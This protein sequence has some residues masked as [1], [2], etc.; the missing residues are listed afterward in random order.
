MSKWLLVLAISQPSPPPEGDAVRL[1]RAAL[2][3]SAGIEQTRIE[4]LRAEPTEWPD[5]GLGCPEPGKMYAQMIVPGFR[6]TLRASGKTYD[7]HVGEGR[8]IVCGSSTEKEKPEALA[9][10]KAREDLARTL[11]IPA[12]AVEVMST[13]RASW[14]DA[15]LGCPEPDRM[16][17]QM[18]TEGWVIKLRVRGKNY[19]YHAD[20]SR[21]VSC[22]N[23]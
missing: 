9:A 10:Q 11:G 23:R 12:S 15:S 3:A 21:V 19:E 6:V 8:A 14:P 7:V 1:A 16:Y 17:A 13:T 22:G 4:T 2:A 5:A 18:I 20:A